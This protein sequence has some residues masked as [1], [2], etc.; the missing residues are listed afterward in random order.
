MTYKQRRFKAM[1]LA[2]AFVR[3]G[4]QAEPSF[5][6]SSSL[7]MPIALAVDVTV[8]NPEYYPIECDLKMQATCTELSQKGNIT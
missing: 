6:F 5:D 3:Q 8:T 7:S 1:E 4:L 2:S